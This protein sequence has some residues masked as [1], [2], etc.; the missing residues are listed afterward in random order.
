MDPFGRF[1]AL[2][3]GISESD[4]HPACEL[5]LRLTGLHGRWEWFLGLPAAGPSGIGFKRCQLV[6]LLDRF[7]PV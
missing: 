1:L 4:H 7:L 2:Q 6:P 3:V 5:R